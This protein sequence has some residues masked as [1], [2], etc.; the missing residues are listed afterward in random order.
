[1]RLASWTGIIAAAALTCGAAARGAADD[2]PPAFASGGATILAWTPA[3]QA[4][5]YR[6]ME[7]LAPARVVKRGPTVR[8]LPVAKTQ[9]E[10]TFTYG[11]KNYTLQSYMD[12]YRL[13]GVIAIKDG[14]IIL[15]RYGLG[16]TP[17]DRWTSFSVAKSVTS[18]LIGAAI[19]DGRIGALDD[20]I[21]RYIPQLTDGDA[22]VR[23]ALELGDVVGDR[24]IEALDVTVLDGRADQ[25]RGHR[26]GHRE[27]G[28]AVLAR[29]AQAIAL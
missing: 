3:Q 4:Y 7:K 29:A 14:K 19:E 6:H 22:V 16:R 10:P 5:G 17:Q 26:L 20:P 11:G 8:D 24:R 13:S 25:G 2:Q 23:A 18:T 1:M 9:V 21:T 12:A 28:P 27:R 15:E